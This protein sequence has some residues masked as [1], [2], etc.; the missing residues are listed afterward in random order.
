MLWREL[1]SLSFHAIRRSLK[2]DQF[3]KKLKMIF[4]NC[5]ALQARS[6]IFQ[7]K[8]VSVAKE[9][10]DHVKYALGKLSV[11]VKQSS[12]FQK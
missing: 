4:K 9:P 1:Y 2:S 7:V 6:M 8:E 3:E 5:F 12:Q 10:P 11:R